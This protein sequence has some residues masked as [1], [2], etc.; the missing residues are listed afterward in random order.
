MD[1]V[2]IFADTERSPELRHELPVAVTD[3]FLYA[4]VGGARHVLISQ[5][6]IPRLAAVGTSAVL[7]PMDEFGSHELAEQGLGRDELLEQVA[8]RFC[9]E[10]GI[11]RAVVPG[12]VPVRMADVLREAGIEVEPRQSLFND[13][14]RVK[15]PTQIEGIRRAQLAAEA[16]MAAVASLIARAE[17]REDG[18][19]VDGA[20]LTSERLRHVLLVTFLEHGAL[21]GRVITSHGPQSAV[22]HESGSGVILPGEPVVVDI[23]PQDPQTACYTDMTRTFVVGEPPAELA[24]YQRVVKDAHDAA[25]AEVRPGADARTVYGAAASVI[26]RAGYPT[27][28]TRQPGKP[29]DHGFY[30]VLGHGV[31]LEVHEA[32]ILGTRPDALIVG[33][34]ITIEPG[35]YRP[36]FGGCRLED[37]LVV[38]DEGA[39]MLTTFPYDLIPAAG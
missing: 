1:D 34:V 7:H 27:I 13:R 23:W 30:H 14:R 15:T 37:I 9:R 31:G 33:D 25:I 38:T 26:E 24:E 32:P 22:G 20:P 18:V 35:I 28:R 36:G 19:V 29:L 4:E 39:D 2:L 5:M 6:E 17:P 3:P 8:V 11:D 16:G 10:Q 21:A 12:T